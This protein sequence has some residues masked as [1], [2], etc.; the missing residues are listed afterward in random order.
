M[1]LSR[2]EYWSGSPFPTEGDLPDPEIESASLVSPAW[3]VDSLP[4]VQ[5]SIQRK[6]ISTL[7]AHLKKGSTESI[8]NI[9]SC[10]KM[11]LVRPFGSEVGRAGPC[12]ELFL[13]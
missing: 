1:G 6:I 2:Q 13:L 10:L 9:T 3:Q 4:L 7:K 12:G 8:G 5:P 11:S